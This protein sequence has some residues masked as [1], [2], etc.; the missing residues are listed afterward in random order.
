M[1]LDFVTYTNQIKQIQ[2][3]L[4]NRYVTSAVKAEAKV[5]WRRSA[6]SAS[7]LK[8][9]LPEQIAAFNQQYYINLQYK[10]SPYTMH[11]QDKNAGVS[12]KKFQSIALAN[13][14]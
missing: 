6:D 8:K 9:S 10:L 11:Q 12:L 4:Q 5:D 7:I 3:D 14:R 1:V 13:N 2:N